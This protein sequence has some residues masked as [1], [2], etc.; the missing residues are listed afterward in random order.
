MIDL[1]QQEERGDL[2]SSSR[3]SGGLTDF[4]GRAGDT[5]GIG[6]LQGALRL[7]QRLVSSHRVVTRLNG[8]K[9][10]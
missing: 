4:V 6:A 7:R 5:V 8:K 10:K 9:N 3:A 2:L 1:K